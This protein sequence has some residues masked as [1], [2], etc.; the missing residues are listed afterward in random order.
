VKLE[1]KA[2]IITG[3]GTGI[4]AATARRFVE[5]G[6]RVVLLGPEQEPLE[7]V[8]AEVEG[9]AVLGDAAN[10][11]D[12]R[13]AVRTAIERFG[14]LD[15]L[16]TCAGGGEGFALLTDLDEPTWE[17][18][19]RINL[20]TCVVSSREAIP[21]LLEREGSSIVVIAS[22]AGITAGS[23]IASYNTSKTA[24]LG[25]VRSLAVDYGPQGLRVNAICPGWTRTRMSEP[26]I[27]RL[28]MER[29]ISVEDAWARANSGVP[30]RRTAEPAEIAAVCAFLASDEA[31]F[32]TGTAI[33][34]DGGQSAVN[35]GALPLSL[36]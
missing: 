6:A 35:V 21:A 28:A 4:G 2:A 5:E 13:K 14:G 26:I 10:A 9:V 3:G 19:I 36:D 17:Q 29:G 11:D 1:G 12:A 22:V 18:H 30:L 33:I 23:G 27:E 16:A 8:A 15:V 24:L 34:A 32:V 20:T 25:F 7:H 31:S